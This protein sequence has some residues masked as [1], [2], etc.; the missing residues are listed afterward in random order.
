MQINEYILDL[1]LL[2]KNTFNA[3]IIIRRILRV[4]FRGVSSLSQKYLSIS[5]VEDSK[6]SPPSLPPPAP[7]L[8]S[9][10]L[11]EKQGQQL[12]K[13]KKHR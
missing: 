4:C 10:E 9:M 7:L 11:T 5:N 3:N 6:M 2:N 1:H 8:P 13:H 12:G